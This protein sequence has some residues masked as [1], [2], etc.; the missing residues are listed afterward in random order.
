MHTER[1]SWLLTPYFISIRGGQ[2]IQTFF[3]SALS[4]SIT[5]ELYNFLEAPEMVISLLAN[6]LPAQSSYFIQVRTS[7]L[8]TSC[9]QHK[10]LRLF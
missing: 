8:E 6:S 10:I 9:I 5:A 4:G 7:A 1:E 2:F 3:V